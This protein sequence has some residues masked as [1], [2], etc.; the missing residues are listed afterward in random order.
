[1][2]APNAV[3]KLNLYVLRN[4]P[5]N[6]NLNSF[7]AKRPKLRA[8]I[9]QD[10]SM[11]KSPSRPRFLLIRT[12]KHTGIF[13]MRKEG[14]ELCPDGTELSK[15][16]QVQGHITHVAIRDRFR[17]TLHLALELNA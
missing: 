5:M 15:H 7:Q 6:V 1:M 14:E 9:D 16:A 17:T 3:L 10:N 4:A 8:E 13:F 12:S 11:A 2:I